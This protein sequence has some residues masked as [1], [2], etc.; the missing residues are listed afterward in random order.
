MAVNNGNGRQ[1]RPNLPDLAIMAGSLSKAMDKGKA[2][3]SLVGVG[4]FSLGF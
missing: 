3:L 2:R 4:G 1:V